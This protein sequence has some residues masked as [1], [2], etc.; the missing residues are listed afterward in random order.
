ME[1]LQDKRV[2]LQPECKKRLQDRID[3]WSYAAKVTP[4]PSPPLGFTSLLLQPLL[5]VWPAGGAGG[6]LL[7]P[8][9]AGDDVPVQELHPAGDG[10]QRVRAL[11][12][13]AA[14][15]TPHQARDQ[16][17]EGPVEGV[18]MVTPP[19]LLRR[20]ASSSSSSSSC[21]QLTCT[22]PTPVH[23]SGP[24]LPLPLQIFAL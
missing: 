9:R 10:A 19:E 20:L 18:A 1:T 15:R 24:P 23:T 2:R 5:S 12:G 6:R 14:V 22:V 11:P 21:N 3:M 4:A 8:G 13:G 17:T 7:G 16:R